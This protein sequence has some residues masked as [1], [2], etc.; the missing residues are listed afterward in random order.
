MGMDG[1]TLTY[2]KTGGIGFQVKE[3]LIGWDVS[4]IHPSILTRLYYL[5]KQREK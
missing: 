5:K 4:K 2:F 3:S 1:W